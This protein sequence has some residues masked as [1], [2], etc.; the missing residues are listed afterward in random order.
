MSEPKSIE[1]VPNWV[2]VNALRC[3]IDAQISI[4]AKLLQHLDRDQRAKALS[5]SGVVGRSEQLQGFF[6]FYKQKF[7]GG[8]NTDVLEITLKQYQ[9]TL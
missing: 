1:E 6:E 9:E 7:G 3:P 8:F 4:V 2:I 5:M